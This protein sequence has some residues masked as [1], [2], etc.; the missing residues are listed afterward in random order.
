VTAGSKS[1]DDLASAAEPIV[2]VIDDDLAMRTTLSSLFRSMGLRV[3]LFGSAQEFAQIKMPDVASCLVLDIR[4]PGV[5]GLDFQTKLAEADIRIPIIFMTGHGDIPMSVR[6]MKAGAVDFLTKPFRD[7]DILDAVVRAIERDKNRRD[8]EKGISEL[9]VLFDSLTSRERE[10]MEH[11]VAGLM[12]KQ[13]A[14]K[15]GITE[16]TVKVHR[17]HMMRKMK[18]RSVID[19]VAM[20]DQLGIRRPKP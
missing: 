12:N 16:I 13:I 5:S 9:R 7:Q 17:G 15:L 18:A 10:V 1:R 8:G 11:V 14:A 2:F 6:A 4:L 19:L 3:E 20:A